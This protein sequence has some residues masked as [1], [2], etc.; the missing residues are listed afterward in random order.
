MLSKAF[1][2]YLQ[3][4]NLG[5]LG[6][7]V[8]AKFDEHD[9]RS[10]ARGADQCIPA[11]A[12][13][14]VRELINHSS[15]L[16]TQKTESAE[17]TKDPSVRGQKSPSISASAAWND[18]ATQACRVVDDLIDDIPQNDGSVELEYKTT[19][20]KSTSCHNEQGGSVEIQRNEQLATKS[21]QKLSSI[22]HTGNTLPNS[23]AGI[24]S[25]DSNEMEKR[26]TMGSFQERASY[27]ALGNNNEDENNEDEEDIASGDID[28]LIEQHVV[29]VQP[30]PATPPQ[31]PMTQIMPTRPEIS[32]ST[33][34][35]ATN[36]CERS[37]VSPNNKRRTHDVSYASDT[38]SPV[39][40]QKSTA[41]KTR[42]RVRFTHA[43][44]QCL[45]R[46]V[47]QRGRRWVRYSELAFWYAI[48][49]LLNQSCWKCTCKR[50]HKDETTEPESDV[51]VFMHT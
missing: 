18:A 19:D 15:T 22:V 41:T 33:P 12:L 29:R 3:M 4:A 20:T 26:C 5:I 6:M 42:K 13:E 40:V 30:D 9:T 44:E 45:V 24:K 25:A 34:R 11:L 36:R 16:L 27:S 47:R 2:N 32:P 7:V 49:I 48:I 50:V 21:A 37:T 23:F 8:N 51:L 28:S 17:S 39:A 43:E 46:L 14:L 35:N 38:A 1:V 31:T 10:C